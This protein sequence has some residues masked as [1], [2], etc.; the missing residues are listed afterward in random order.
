MR[1]LPAAG[2]RFETL[3]DEHGVDLAPR[4]VETLQVNITKLCNQ[5][6]RHCHV[7]A[8]PVRTEMMATATL[9]RC[10]ALLAASPE[11]TTL[12]ITGG[13]PELHPEFARLVD[14]ARALGK[15]VLVRHNLTVQ[16]DPHP[17]TGASARCT[18]ST[19]RSAPT[20][21][22]RRPRSRRSTA[23]S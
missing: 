9:D 3:L 15:R 17:L 12:D 6:C 16:L 21:R 22:R 19:T 11:L 2:S 14:A 13:A 7:D 4:A 18:S 5:A 10:L 1:P 20:C 8:S 23:A